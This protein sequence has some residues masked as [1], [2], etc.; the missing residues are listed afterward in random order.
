MKTTKFKDMTLARRAHYRLI[1]RFGLWAS[2]LRILPEGIFLEVF[3]K[4]K[5]K[6]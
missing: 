5:A 3:V 1:A 2:T 6:L 4:P